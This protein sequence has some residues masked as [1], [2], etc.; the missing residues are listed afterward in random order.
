MRNFFGYIR[1]STPKQGETVSLPEQKSAILRYAERNSFTIVDWFEERRTAAK[2][3]RPVFS[4]MLRLLR[5]GKAEGVVIHKI[6]RGARNLKDWADLGELVDAG[7]EVHTANETLDLRSRGGR[8]AADIQAVVAADYIRNLR[9]ETK[10]GFYGRLKQGI[11]PLPA[12][13]GYLDRGKG[14]PKEPDPAKAPLVR[15]AFELYATC[16]YNLHTL[17]DELH[18][19]GLRNRS[20]GRLS[21]TGLSTILNNPFY[22]GLI[23]LRRTGEVFPGAH[24]P[25]IK[26]ALFERVQEV[27]SGKTNR[28][29][30][31]HAFTFRR[32]LRCVH[33]QHALIGER[34]KGHVYYRCHGRDCPRTSLREESLDYS[35]LAAVEPLEMSPEEQ[36][37]VAARITDLRTQAREKVEEHRTALA[38]AAGKIVDRMRRLTD[39]YVDGAITKDAFDDRRAALVVEQRELADAESHAEADLARIRERLAREL[40]LA[41]DAYLGYKMAD[42]PKKRRLLLA[43]TS[44]RAVD[45]RNL[46][47]ALGFPFSEIARRFET[48]NGPLHRD[49]PRTWDRLM[50]K[51]LEALKTQS[52][53]AAPCF[54]GRPTIPDETGDTIP[55]KRGRHRPTHSS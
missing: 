43:L 27:L 26:K 12:P 10:K 14:K 8:L 30:D 44:N 47:I 36:A 34:Q 38:L 4:E 13:L 35:A 7:I 18:R 24:A 5:H 52:P 20:G 9:E 2:R 25:L 45:G 29:V 46:A 28:R 32:L 39:G 23:R 42:P 16:R 17:Q 15:Q 33:C 31:R 40:E 3:G 50:T 19:R 41:I 37:H 1:V 48:T 53:P 21:L 55:D 11:Y 6:D 51:L 22:I 54:D 49:I